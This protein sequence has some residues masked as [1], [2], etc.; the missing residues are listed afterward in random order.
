MPESSAV[1]ITEVVP[2]SD[3]PNESAAMSKPIRLSI[4]MFL[5]FFVWGV[6]FVTMGGYL[7]NL[8]AAYEE[9]GTLNSIVANIYA[10]QTWAALCAPLI[11]GFVADRLL[12]KEHVLAILHLAGA[13]LLYWVST[14][15]DSPTMF[16]VAM[17]AFF[18]CYMPT[19]AVVN[20]LT[21][22]NVASP[23]RDFPKIRLWGTIGWIVGGLVVSQSFFGIFP[24]K[25]LPGVDDAGGSAVQFQLA[26]A[27]SLIYGIYAFTLPSS[28]PEG[29]GKPVNIIKLLGFDAIS[30]LKNPSYAVFALCSFLIC[31]PLAFYYA[32]TGDF[33]KLMAF[34]DDTGGVMALGQVSEIV[35]MAL[36]PVFL[37][38]LGVKKMLLVG[39]IAWAL[40]YVLFG[41]MPSNSAMLI[42]GIMLHGICYDFFFVTGQ[43]Y[44]DRVA[45][46][47]TRTSAQALV[48]LLTYGAGMLVGNYVSGFWGDSVVKLDATTAEGWEAGAA[49]FW[50]MPAVFA[51]VVA[52]IFALSFW[53]KTEVTEEMAEEK[54][55][56]LGPATT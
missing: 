41:L 23:D 25:V 30:L 43:L 44:T 52:V 54:P 18:I 28:P 55:I 48:G 12:N 35:F 17:L 15:E 4:M 33:V 36:V 53:D 24:L 27:A 13:G 40:R 19:L 3:L 39:M 10:T 21:F 50:L 22:Q 9:K 38:R 11:V 29:K 20:T 47:E 7:T 46:P 5:Q 16:F 2:F 1:R 6:F 32:R 8:F 34:G 51:G 45:P 49:M 14:I 31:I 56:D 26:A 42:L 37:A